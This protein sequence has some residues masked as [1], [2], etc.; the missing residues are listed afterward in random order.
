MNNVSITPSYSM[1]RLID[2]APGD[3]ILLPDYE[4]NLSP[5]LI[6]TFLFDEDEETAFLELTANYN[7][8]LITQHRSLN[9]LKVN[10]HWRFR[11]LNRIP[12]DFKQHS[13]DTPRGVLIIGRNGILFNSV[14]DPATGFII[15]HV[16][17]DIKNS[18]VIQNKDL[19]ASVCFYSKW[20]IETRSDA[21]EP[22]QEL[23]P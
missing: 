7:I 22:W 1:V 17:V 11:L 13:F 12:S 9:V 6:I 19:N 15:D 16:M 3:L 8:H 5:C 4:N 23:C 21:S 14:M 10:D 2:T 18:K 20:K